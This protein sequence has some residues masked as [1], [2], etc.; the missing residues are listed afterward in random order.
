[1]LSRQQLQ[2]ILDTVYQL[3]SVDEGAEVTVEMNPDDLDPPPARPKGTLDT[4]RTPPVREGSVLR[5]I[6]RGSLG[7]QTFDDDLL[8]LV[9]LLA[10]SEGLFVRPA[11]I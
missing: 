2:Q 6:N 3:F 7:V 10:A 9:R 5:H 11:A 1:M 4:S 8:R